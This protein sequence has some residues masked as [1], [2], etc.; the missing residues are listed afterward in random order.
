M[1]PTTPSSTRSVVSAADRVEKMT[2]GD[3]GGARQA[4]KAASVISWLERFDDAHHIPAPS[5]NP[6]PGDGDAPD[7]SWHALPQRVRVA[8]GRDPAARRRRVDPPSPT[9]DLHPTTEHD[10]EP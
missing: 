4:E 10:E 8:R 5:D 2:V 9:P 6:F 1:A 3:E 7:A